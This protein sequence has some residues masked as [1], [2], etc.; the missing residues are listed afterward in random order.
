MTVSPSE[1]RIGVAAPSVAGTSDSYLAL[2]PRSGGTADRYPSRVQVR[3]VSGDLPAELARQ[4]RDAGR[5]AVDTETSGLDWRTDSLQL[6]QLF[7]AV[8]GAVLVRIEG[9]AP[10]LRS[11]LEDQTVTKVFHFAPFDLRF[12]EAAIGARTAPVICTKAASKLL[13]PGLPAQAHSLGALLVR[14]FGLELD[15]GAVRTSDWGSTALTDAQTD[16]AAG[17]VI[18]LL[19]LADV[20]L[21][22]LQ[23]RGLT[24]EFEAICRYMP[25][26]AHLDVTG[27]P[28]PLTY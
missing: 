15:K 11:L 14:H 27:V 20:E 12:L 8:V 24:E 2:R 13:R 1:G 28:N 3:V 21:E 18:N 4:L 25:V 5:V 7:N 10:Q 9:D 6:C 26:D 19:R 16:Y 23:T 22:L 17:D